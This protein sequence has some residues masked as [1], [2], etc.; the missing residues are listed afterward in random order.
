[1]CHTQDMTPKQIK[2]QEVDE[3]LA[4][5]RAEREGRNPRDKRFTR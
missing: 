5:E 4:R 3:C 2:E 1:M